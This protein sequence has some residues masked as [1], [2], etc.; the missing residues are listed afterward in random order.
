MDKLFDQLYRLEHV[1]TLIRLKATGCP[2]VFA[3]KLN[4]SERSLK[5]LVQQLRDQGFPIGYDTQRR[6]YYYQQEVKFSFQ[7]LVNGEQEFCI[8]GGKNLESA[9]F[10]PW[11]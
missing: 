6:T 10:W 7:I 3:E 8:K 1:H 4:I 2:R 11:L 9:N 5:R